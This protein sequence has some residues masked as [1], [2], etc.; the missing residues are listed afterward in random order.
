MSVRAKFRCS[1]KTITDAGWRSPDG[2]KA[3]PVEAVVLVPV[4]GDSPENKT[5]SMHTPSGRLEMS[6]TNPEALNQ[7]ELGLEYF[8]DFTPA[9]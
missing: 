3:P 1:Q 7:F 5:W 9:S 6:I 4:S 8:V 2:K